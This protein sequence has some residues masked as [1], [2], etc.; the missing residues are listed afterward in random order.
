[1]TDASEFE[2]V[3]DL[4]NEYLERL[5][6]GEQPTVEEYAARYP[7][8]ANRIR[9]VF[10]MMRLMEDNAPDTTVSDDSEQTTQQLER[11][12]DFRIL[13]EIGR[14]GMGVVYEAVQESLGRHVALK[15]FPRHAHLNPQHQERFKRESRSAAMLH[16]TNI[17][18]VFAVGDDQGM[19]YYAMQYIRGAGLDEVIIEL[20]RLGPVGQKTIAHT[21]HTS[22]CRCQSGRL[23]D[24][25]GLRICGAYEGRFFSAAEIVERQLIGVRCPSARAV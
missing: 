3:I 22:E 11:L 9:D 5:R 17:V 10:P 14:G 20:N 4:A 18:P 15:V 1:M 2:P 8:L 6:A 13:R 19:L 25:D 21:R 12:G 24:D 23:V 7:D 16:H